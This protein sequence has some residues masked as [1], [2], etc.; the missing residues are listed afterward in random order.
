MEKPQINFNYFHFLALVYLLSNGGKDNYLEITSSQLSKILNRSQQTAS[1]VLIDLEKENLIERVKNNKRFGMKLSQSGFEVLQDIY[2]ILKSSM[3]Y[4]Q[5]QQISFKGKIVT[6]MGEG[7]YYMSLEGYKK[8]F[9]DKLGYEPF[10]GTLNVKIEDKF[11]MNSRRDL[12]NQPSIHVEGFK[13]TDRSFGWVRCYPATLVKD[14]SIR[15]TSP[16]L[17]PNLEPGSISNSNQN[18]MTDVHV[19]L[20]ERT[21][22]DNSMIEVIGP[23]NLKAMANLKNGDAVLISI[24][25]TGLDKPTHKS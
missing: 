9:R 13:N 17:S 21:H 3:E 15:Q 19:L 25:S 20:L 22:H 4:S 23:F 12:I 18:I 10:P 14:Q 7:A 6:G 8:Q 16:R 11:Y 1:K 5:Q 24:K 2:D